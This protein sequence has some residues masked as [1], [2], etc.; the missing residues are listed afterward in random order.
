MTPFGIAFH[1]CKLRERLG[2]E[3][4]LSA[5]C[6][7]Q[8]GRGVAS[9]GSIDAMSQDLDPTQI[10]QLLQGIQATAMLKA[11]I[12]LG[13]FAAL[14]KQ[15]GT[16][17]DVAASIGCP[18]R[19]TGILLDGLA[20]VGLLTRGADGVARYELAPVSRAF[21]V[22]GTPTYLGDASNI[23]ASPLMLQGYVS[24][25]DAV[26]AGGTIMDQHAETPSHAFWETFARSS[27][28]LAMPA[29]HLLAD[30]LGPVAREKRGLRVLDVAAGSGIYGA[31]LERRL[32]AEV[33]FLDW[34]NVLQETRV[35]ADRLGVD[36]SKV[37]YLPGSAFDADLS[38][39]YDIV[40]ASHFFH[41][42]DPATCQSLTHRLAGVLAPG[43]R[44]CVHD[45]V[46][47]PALDNPA[48]T[49][50]SLTM[51]IWTRAG[52][53]YSEADY[54]G[55]MREAGLQQPEKHAAAGMPT[56]WIIAQRP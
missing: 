54:T 21:L 13:V 45:F 8:A 51:L 11:A 25:A 16:A 22:P 20:V 3:Q 41:H 9:K 27:A 18:A 26:R 4:A 56:S 6:L 2:R 55:W 24:L 19:S 48:A 12:D 43:G 42:F 37:R 10:F 52:K 36:P 49:L 46:T 17:D 29:A 32:S 1:L 7:Q 5:A 44:L 28:A 23:F 53:A 15:P 40:V 34:P 50:F 38:G 14:A 47:G 31:T 35:W 30:V 39:P 33:T